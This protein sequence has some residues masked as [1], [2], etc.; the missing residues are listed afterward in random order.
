MDSP[1]RI[2][3]KDLPTNGR[4]IK[5]TVNGEDV[6]V[7][8]I[9]DEFFAVSNVCPHQHFSRIH[10]GMLEGL[11]VTCPMHGWSFDIR[12]G[13][14]VNGAGSLRRYE[15]TLHENEMIVELPGE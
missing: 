1:I 12:S 14:C 4:G 13:A 9:G 3:F 15:V 2:P 7:F 8:C 5:V 10:E 11:V 6:A